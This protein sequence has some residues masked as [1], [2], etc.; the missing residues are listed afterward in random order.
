MKTPVMNR[1]MIRNMM[2]A[3]ARS[4]ML[5][6]F[7]ALSL[8]LNSDFENLNFSTVML[9][10]VWILMWT[11]PDEALLLRGRDGRETLERFVSDFVVQRVEE[12]DVDMDELSVA[13]L[14][15]RVTVSEGMA[16]KVV[17]IPRFAIVTYEGTG[18]Q[19]T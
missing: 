3:R 4:V 16:V 5:M 18:R 1:M 15:G 2:L 7:L 19:R 13:L 9:S 14:G 11:S 8:R 6:I 12:S 10:S 17:S